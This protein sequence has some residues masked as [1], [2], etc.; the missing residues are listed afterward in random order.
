M[1]G[2]ELKT[3]DLAI[4]QETGVT[5]VHEPEK[6]VQEGLLKIVPGKSI[7]NDGRHDLEILCE[8]FP[9]VQVEELIYTEENGII[10]KFINKQ[11][12]QQN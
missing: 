8:R 6:Y 12:Q 5:S 4:A 3:A 2:H 11:W 1:G 10:Y 7:D 9:D